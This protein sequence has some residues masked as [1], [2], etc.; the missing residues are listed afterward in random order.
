MVDLKIKKVR[1][2][3]KFPTKAHEDDACF[4]LYA[5]LEKDKIEINPHKTVLIPT[6]IATAIPKGYWAPIYAR[7]GV[8]TKRGLRLAQGTAVIDNNYRGEWLIPLHNDF[9][10]PQFV[11]NGERICQFHLQKMYETNLIEVEDLDE[12]DRGNTGFGD[13][14]KK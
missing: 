5:V 9:D 3:A 10:V 6:G 14:G 1:K 12:T 13:S 7:S 2:E 4:D 11:E 8:A